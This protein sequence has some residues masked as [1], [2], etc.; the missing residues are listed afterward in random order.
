MN[1]DTGVTHKCEIPFEYSN[2]CSVEKNESSLWGKYFSS[3]RTPT[4]SVVS[5]TIWISISS[6][7]IREVISKGFQQSFSLSEVYITS[8]WRKNT[9]RLH[10][11]NLKQSNMLFIDE[12]KRWKVLT[13]CHC[14]VEMKHEQSQGAEDGTEAVARCSLP[15]L[16]QTKLLQNIEL[17]FRLTL[18]LHHDK[19]GV[20]C[21]TGRFLPCLQKSPET[22]SVWGR[23]MEAGTG[24]DH[25]HT[26]LVFWTS[27]FGSWRYLNS[28]SKCF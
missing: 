4:H 19:T 16:W 1:L 9:S 27:S 7:H 17:F 15:Q 8:T 2:P 22:P 20:L 11:Y 3:D 13:E 21:G 23:W 10:H 24:S 5:V 12:K 18:M 26:Q 28:F 6:A 14:D 25:K